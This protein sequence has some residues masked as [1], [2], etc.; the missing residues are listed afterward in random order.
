MIDKDEVK[1][2]MAR[3]LKQPVTKLEDTTVL[4]DLVTDSFVLVEMVIELQEEL[5]VRLIQED[6]KEVKTVSDLTELL[7][8]NARR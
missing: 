2:R 6:L 7:A 5:G 4:T 3:I 8:A 1:K